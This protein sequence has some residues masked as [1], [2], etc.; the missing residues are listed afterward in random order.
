MAQIFLLFLFSASAVG[1]QLSA[2]HLFFPQ[3]PDEFF[4]S[5]HR[6]AGDRL[7]VGDFV[8]RIAFHHHHRDL[9][10]QGSKKG[11]GQ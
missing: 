1:E 11:Q 7:R 9:F 3:F 5:F 2:G 6:A 10:H 8:D 4:L